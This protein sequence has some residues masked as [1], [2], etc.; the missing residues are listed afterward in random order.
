MGMAQFLGSCT[1]VNVLHSCFC[2]SRLPG[3]TL[4]STGVVDARQGATSNHLTTSALQ[5]YYIGHS[6][7]DISGVQGKALQ[8]MACLL[9]TNTGAQQQIKMCALYS[10]FTALF[11]ALRALTRINESSP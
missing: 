6:N 9:F 4:K 5:L 10:Q 1:G 3:P 7:P 2:S 11:S 8:P